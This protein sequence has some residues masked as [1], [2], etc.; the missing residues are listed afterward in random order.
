MTGP[1]GERETGPTGPLDWN[2]WPETPEQAVPV[3]EHLRTLVI[4]R[5]DAPWPPARIAAVDAHYSERDGKT[6][7]AVAEVDPDTLELTRSVLLAQPTRFPYVPGFLSFREVP[8]M[9]AALALLPA[10][11][12][13]VVVDG[14][15]LAHPRRFG[16]ACHLGVVTGLP[17]IGVAKSRLVGRYAEPGPERGASSPMFHHKEMVG[18]A[19]RTRTGTRPIFV[20]VGHRVGL[21]RAVDVVLRLSPKWRLSEPIR[22]ADA[23]SRMHAP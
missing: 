6:W 21:A 11:P 2:D 18:V 4:D 5:D 16:L 12:D 7:A 1:A 8:A 19:L 22:L 3:Q 13:L 9:A 15:G 20:S 14:Q 10:P 17:T 23:V